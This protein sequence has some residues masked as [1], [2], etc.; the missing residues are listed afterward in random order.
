MTKYHNIQSLR[1]ITD[2]CPG[3]WGREPLSELSSL[4]PRMCFSL[5]KLL[6]IFEFLLIF[7]I[8]AQI[9]LFPEKPSLMDCPS[10]SWL[11]LLCA[12]PTFH[13][14]PLVTVACNPRP[15]FTRRM[16][17]EDQKPITKDRACHMILVNIS[18]M[19][20]DTP[21]LGT[22]QDFWLPGPPPPRLPSCHTQILDVTFGISIPLGT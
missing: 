2:C 10:L 16:V 21:L 22:R 15:S 17:Y 13:F 8:A 1:S 3:M 4:S 14:S 20:E 6:F 11:F 7:V 18:P 5:T 12:S 9:T 19:N